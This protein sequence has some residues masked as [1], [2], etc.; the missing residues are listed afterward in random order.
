MEVKKHLHT[1]DIP[2]GE[3]N[4]TQ[5]NYF[6]GLSL[7]RIGL[8]ATRQTAGGNVFIRLETDFSGEFGFRIRH[9]YGQYRN[10]LIGQTWSL[11]THI[12]TLIST[13]SASGPSGTVAVRTPQIRFTSKKLI[14]NYTLSLGLEY[15]KPQLAQLNEVDIKSFQIIPDITARI[16]KRGDWGIV[17]ATGLLTLLSG[18]IDSGGSQVRTGWGAGVSTKLNSGENGSWYI[19]I[20]GGRGITRYINDFNGRG[21]DVI[22]SPDQKTVYLPLTL[23]GNIGYEHHWTDRIYSDIVVSG[24]FL[25]SKDSGSDDFYN[26]GT[27]ILFNSFWNVTD[28]ARVGLEYIFARRVDKGG[29]HGGAHRFSLLFYYDF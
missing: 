27:N 14:P 21:L 5:P 25:E 15:F 20:V 3:R 22:L 10:I 2:T 23:G 28:G 4:F 7:R 29:D 13:V 11:F 9:A 24:V 12:T 17:Q 8:E 18:S 6:N 19:R 1:F 16:E 26:Y